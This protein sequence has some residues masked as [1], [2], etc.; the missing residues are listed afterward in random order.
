MHDEAKYIFNRFNFSL[1]ELV[2]GDT[3]YD[4]VVLADASDMKGL[5]GNIDTIKVVE[6][7]DHRKINDAHLFPNAKVQIEMVGAAATLVAEKFY[8]S[9]TEISK[10]SATLL[11][12]AIVSNT[13]NFKATLTTGRDVQMAEWLKEQAGLYDNFWKD[14][15]MAKSDLGGDKLK[16]RMEGEFANFEI[17]GKKFGIVQVEI[18]NVG[19][20]VEGRLPE[21]IKNL[22][23]LNSK[24]ELNFIFQ[25]TLDLENGRN[26]F[27]TNDAE[28]QEIL[29]S[30]LGVKFE[31]RIAIRDGLIM[32]KQIVP[33]I[34]DFL[35]K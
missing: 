7:I 16:L 21:I 4:A 12:G 22:E 6:I 2:T 29:Q 8:K 26:V 17:A 28:A 15:F 32:R 23:D 31:N 11:Y 5:E 34:K 13:L 18:V 27:M 20:L 10:M 30:I 33:S 3:G 25:T 19:E 14:L 24:Y 1:P 9:N 35:N